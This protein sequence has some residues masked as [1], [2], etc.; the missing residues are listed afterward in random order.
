M[1][2]DCFG[3]QGVSYERLSRRNDPSNLAPM[4]ERLQ[5]GWSHGANP[6]LRVVV[7]V[8]DNPHP[9]KR[10]RKRA[11]AVLGKLRPVRHVVER[12]LVE[13]LLQRTGGHVT[14]A[15]HGKR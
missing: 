15:S 2:V 9:L 4:H 14:E 12:H 5:R 11:L 8:G 3:G 6:L 7:V 10:P 13:Q 1:G